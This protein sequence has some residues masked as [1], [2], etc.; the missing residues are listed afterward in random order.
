MPFTGP[1]KKTPVHA[2]SGTA[3]QTL[4]TGFRQEN[5]ELQI[6]PE[7]NKI[8]KHCSEEEKENIVF[9]SIFGLRLLFE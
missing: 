9:P 3:V 7:W 2:G 8:I 4:F 5:R 1:A 6:T